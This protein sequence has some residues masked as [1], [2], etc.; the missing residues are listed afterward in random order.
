M[1]KEKKKHKRCILKTRRLTWI[2]VISL[3]PM[4]PPAPA[5][6]EIEFVKTK[7]KYENQQ[8]PHYRICL[9]SR[10][11]GLFLFHRVNMRKLRVNM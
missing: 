4:R 11:E 7:N 1:K 5:G 6:T 2:S 10:T 8:S 3:C 9:S